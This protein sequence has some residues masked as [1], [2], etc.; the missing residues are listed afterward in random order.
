MVVGSDSDEKIFHAARTL[1]PFLGL[2]G[3]NLFL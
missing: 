1:N 2:T 3:F